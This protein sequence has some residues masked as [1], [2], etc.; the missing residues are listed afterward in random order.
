MSANNATREQ[1]EDY[2]R[3]QSEFKPKEEKAQATGHYIVRLPNLDAFGLSV[4]QKAIM[5]MR[6]MEAEKMMNHPEDYVD[7]ITPEFISD[8]LNGALQDVMEINF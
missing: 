8:F 1:A 3:T 7:N 6:E 4:H 5:R 2:F